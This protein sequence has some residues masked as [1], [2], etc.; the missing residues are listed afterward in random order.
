MVNPR[1]CTGIQRYQYVI[2]LM[3]NTVRSPVLF[4]SMLLDFFQLVVGT[5]YIL[6]SKNQ[7]EPVIVTIIV[8]VQFQFLARIQY[9]N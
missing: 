1:R 8:V 4:I 9:T 3:A 7:F 6:S 2:I 5:Y